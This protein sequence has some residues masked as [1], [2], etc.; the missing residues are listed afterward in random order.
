LRD[1]LTIHKNDGSDEKWNLPSF[2]GHE[3]KKSK[4]RKD[5]HEFDINLQQTIVPR[6]GLW[7]LQMYLRTWKSLVVQQLLSSSADTRT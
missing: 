1:T 5:E 3:N 4:L 7:F 6:R 2:Q